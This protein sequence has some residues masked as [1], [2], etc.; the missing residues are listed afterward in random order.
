MARRYRATKKGTEYHIDDP[1]FRRRSFESSDEYN[2]RVAQASQ[3]LFKYR[4]RWL[5][6]AQILARIL[7]DPTLK[8]AVVEPSGKPLLW[9]GRALF[10]VTVPGTGF[11][12]LIRA[13]PGETFE[14][15]QILKAH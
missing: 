15:G 5:T 2:K 1:V 7:G 10:R 8:D 3:G 11:E 12:M 6:R 14:G 4:G 9:G 13:E